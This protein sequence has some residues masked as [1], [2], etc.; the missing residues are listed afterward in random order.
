MFKS[1]ILFVFV[2]VGGQ[3]F[4]A[5]FEGHTEFESYDVRGTY[6]V[7]CLGATT[8]FQ[9]H[10]CK[11]YGMHPFNWARFS[12]SPK[13]YVEYVTLKSHRPDG[14][15]VTKRLQW[16][17]QLEQSFEEVN[18]W[19]KSMFV[20]PLLS[21]GVNK[22]D[23]SFTVK[24][25]VVESGSFDVTVNKG[26]H[27]RCETLTETKKNS[28]YCDDSMEACTYYFNKQKNCQEIE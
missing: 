18:L 6:K 20:K 14:K 15:S 8:K 22:V 2:L 16:N 4:S 3:A 26:N 21:H 1:I 9:T 27:Y 13:N 23:Y 25:K 7:T 11:A 19:K 17:E 5:D 28:K 10:L 12:H 24:N